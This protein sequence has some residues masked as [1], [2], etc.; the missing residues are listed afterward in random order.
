M[1][2]ATQMSEF[3]I[4]AFEKYVNRSCIRSTNFPATTSEASG[5]T[6]YIQHEKV[7]PMV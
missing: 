1:Y 4:Q 6:T 3:I 7:S 5:G 2:H